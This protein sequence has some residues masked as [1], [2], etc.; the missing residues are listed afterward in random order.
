MLIEDLKG[1]V[2]VARYLHLNPVRVQGLELGKAEQRRA[3]VADIENPGAALAKERLRTLDGYAWSSWQV[4]AGS[5]RTSIVEAAERI[6][7]QRWPEA[8]MPTEAGF[9][10]G[11]FSRPCG[12]RDIG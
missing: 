9:E 12:N 10:T 6:G 11:Y 3:K 2:E 4:Y 5:E 7:G 8:L 1:A